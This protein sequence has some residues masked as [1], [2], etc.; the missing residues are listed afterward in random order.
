LLVWY[1]STEAW[2]AAAEGGPNLSEALATDFLKGPLV[3]WANYW[4]A[5]CPHLTALMVV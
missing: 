4:T 1:D 3:W 5:P 2:L